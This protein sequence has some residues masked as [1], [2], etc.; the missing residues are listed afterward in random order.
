MIRDAAI[1]EAVGVV[2][3]RFGIPPTRNAASVTE[4]GCSLVSEALC[5]YT[6][7]QLSEASIAAIWQRAGGS[8]QLLAAMEGSLSL[9]SDKSP[10]M[11]KS[12]N[13]LVRQS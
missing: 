7:E 13:S 6:N 10:V 5:S 2:S 1:V 8:K 11:R 4:S 9:V 12:A 3:Q